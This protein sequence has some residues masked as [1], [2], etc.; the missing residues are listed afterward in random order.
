MVTLY[1]DA[2][3]SRT[4]VLLLGGP[5]VSSPA[6]VAHEAERRPNDAQGAPSA[7]LRFSVSLFECAQSSRAVIGRSGDFPV[8]FDDNDGLKNRRLRERKSAI[9]QSA[10][11][12]YTYSLR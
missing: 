7:R 1:T 8:E 4:R 2:F 3:S 6:A 5:D 10:D 12:T 11:F 9:P